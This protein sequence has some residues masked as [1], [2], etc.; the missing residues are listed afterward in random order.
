MG[1]ITKS[2]MTRRVLCKRNRRR[3]ERR[4]CGKVEGRVSLLEDY[5]DI[6]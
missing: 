5:T 6:D 4:L 2:H 3:T 1:I